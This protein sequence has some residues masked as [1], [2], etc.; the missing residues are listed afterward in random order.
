[1]LMT[2][3]ANNHQTLQR[4]LKKMNVEED[5]D[6][7]NIGDEISIIQNHIYFYSLITPNSI[8]KLITEMSRMCKEHLGYAASKARPVEEIN[9]HIQSPGGVASSGFVAYDYICKFNEQVPIYTH[10]EGT[11]ASAATLLTICGAKR[12]IT[13][14]STI[15]I[16][17][18]RAWISGKASAI[19]DEYQNLQKVISI[20]ENIYLKHSKI[21]LE[22]LRKILERD[23]H[24][25][26]SEALN[27]G[28]VDEISTTFF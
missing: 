28:L 17:E 26:A 6:L 19:T 12:F 10:I 7:E 15:L 22:D 20:V 11:V 18:P 16:H 1:M 13:P 5:G 23:I 27:L 4:L 9:L 2:N 25:T 21:N 14:S 8:L 24:F 3:S